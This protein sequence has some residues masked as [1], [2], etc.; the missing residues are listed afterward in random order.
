MLTVISL[1]LEVS[2]GPQPLPS[3]QYRLNDTAVAIVGSDGLV[4][5]KAVGYANII[6][7]VNLD[8]TASAIEVFSY[9]F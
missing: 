6:G 4:T 7:S 8:N 3:V 1:Q 9:L 5:S 2:G